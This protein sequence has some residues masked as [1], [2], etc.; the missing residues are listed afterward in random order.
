ME[1]TGLLAQIEAQ[2]RAERAEKR[3]QDEQAEQATKDL[4]A[5]AEA[6]LAAGDTGLAATLGR[7]A[8]IALMNSQ[9][10]WSCEAA[11]F[12]LCGTDA[13]VHGW[14]DTDRQLAQGQDD[15]ETVLYLAQIATPDVAD[16]ANAALASDAADAATRFLADSVIEAAATDNRVAVARVLANNPGSAVKKAANAA[17]DAGTAEALYEFLSVTYEAAQQEDDA[18]ATAT[19]VANAG[20]YTQAHA[21]AAMEGPAWMRRN[22]IASAQHRTAQLDYDSAAHISGIQGAIAAAAKIAHHA[23]ESAARAQQAAA[24]ARNAA[25]EAQQW[26]D[27]ANASAAQAAT[28]ATQADANADAADQSAKD[29]QASADKAKAAAS[30]ARSAARSANYSANR[31]VD[32]ARRAVASANSAQ[33]SAAS[34]RASAI[35]AGQDAQTA[36]AAASQAHQI[37]AAKRQ[38]EIAAAAKQAAEEAREAKEAGTNP[39]DTTDNDTVK[40]GLPWWKEDARWLA[41]ATNWLSIGFG[42]ASAFTGLVGLAAGFFFPPAVPFIEALASGFAYTS[43]AFSGLNVLFTGIGYGLSSSEFKSSLGSAALGVLTFGQSKWI[44]AAGGSTVVTK[45]SQFGHDLISPVT[46]VLGSLF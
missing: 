46:G 19:L 28:A 13:D 21:Q 18:V 16:A 9:G 31:A 7:K 37:A 29:A 25:A 36:A 12:A 39:A 27:K 15:R 30:T 4:V 6:A 26:S 41:N 14:I 17:L 24:T 35:Q 34:A 22:F 11:R 20:P 38:A 40:G 43:L 45:V 2:E 42:F 3:T 32:A 1:E 23:Q 8:A 33:A 10:S 44:G 5:Q